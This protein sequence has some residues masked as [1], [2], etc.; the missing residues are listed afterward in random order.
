MKK[1]KPHEMSELSAIILVNLTAIAFFF[2]LMIII[3]SKILF[4]QSIDNAKRVDTEAAQHVTDSLKNNFD[5]MTQL[6][7]FPQ[8]L[9]AEVDFRSGT[10]DK[11]TD[12][13]LM[14]LMK[15]NPDIHCAWLVLEKGVHYKDRFY[16]KRYT[17][18]NGAVVEAAV[19]AIEENLKD[20]ATAPWYYRPLV[21]KETYLDA[22]SLHDDYGSNDR[23]P[24]YAATLSAPILVAGEVIGVYTVGLLYKDVL[25]L[26][27]DPLTGYDK[28]AMLMSQD[29][30]IIHSF[31]PELNGKNLAHLGYDDIDSIRDAMEHEREYDNEIMSPLIDKKIFLYLLPISFNS[32]S[33]RQVLYLLM[34]TPLDTLYKDAYFI[35]LIITSISF[36]CMVFIVGII[37]FAAN[38]VVQPIRDLAKKALHVASGDFNVDIFDVPDDARRGKSEVAVLRRA[39]N[40]MLRALH[41]NLRTVEKRVDER[42]S[43][44]TK[45]NNYINLLIESTSN[46]S[47]LLDKDLNILYYSKRFLTLLSIDDSSELLRKPLNVMLHD[48]SDADYA[49]RSKRRMSRIIS[50]EEMFSEDDAITWPNGEKR[51]YRIIYRRVKDDKDNF[52]GMVVVMHDLTD[53]RMEEAE[54]RINDM[55]YSTVVPC[56]V[57]DKEGCI[58]KYNKAAAGI[59]GLPEDLSPEDFDKRYFSMQPELQPNGISTETVKMELIREALEKGFSQVDGQLVKSDGTPLYVN[60]IVAR[61]AWLSGYLMV[62][63]HHD[64][65]DLKLKEAE[66]KETEERIKLM[67]DGNPMICMLGDEYNNILDCNQAALNIFGVSEKADFCRNF[68]KFYPELQPDGSDSFEKLHQI[69]RQFRSSASDIHQYE[70]MFRT[71]K[72]EPL[73]VETTLVRM[74]WKD[75]VR[76]LS[77]VRDLREIKAKEQEMLQSAERERKADLLREAAQ[78]ANEAK[79]QFLANMSHEI[80]TPMNAVLGMSELLLHEKLNKRQQRYAKDIKVSAEALL[81]IINDILDVSK[82]QSGKLSLMPV[83]FDFNMLIDNIGSMMHFLVHGKNII[84][85]L[86]MPEQ[87]PVCLYGDDIRLRQILINLLNNAIKF[88][89]EGYVE[90]AIDFT[91]TTI[92]IAVND[93]GAGIPEESIST[94]FEAFEQADTLMN[95]NTKGTGLGLTITKALVEMMGGHITVES[96]YGRGTSFYVEIPK[97]LGDETLI[98]RVDDKGIEVYAPEAKILVVDD[99]K[100]NLNVACGLLQ[101]CAINVETAESGRQA[102]EMVQQNHFDIVFMD[103]RMP[104]MSGVEATQ[105]IR[106]LGINVPIIALTASA[107]ADAKEMMLEAGMSDYLW[108]PIIKA[109]L[110]QILK[111]WIPADKLLTPQHV[112]NARE[113]SE[114]ERHKDFWEKIGQIE[115]LSISTG[116][117]RVDG[118]RGMYKKT[119]QLMVQEIEKSLKN[120]PDYLS[121]ND[122][123]NFRIEVHGIKGALANIGAMELS[124]KAFS[125]ETASDKAD[126]AFCVSNLPGFLEGLNDLNA[127]LKGAFALISQS[128]GIIEIPPELPHIFEKLTSAFYEMDLA[129]IDEEIEKLTALNPDGG[130]KEEIE[131]I[132]DAVLM[133]DYDTAVK[134]IHILLGDA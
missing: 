93:T 105:A 31:N 63:Y 84:F 32:G 2:I 34:G 104:E 74:K 44:L 120:L 24:E 6:L 27:N 25:E 28:V 66:A 30:T 42:T 90:L 38:R 22:V 11:A 75:T 10:A 92:K 112:M 126:M 108:K 39:F 111:K 8:Q 76:V 109:E 52:E 117:D 118:R 58:V 65:T 88:T 131:K 48:F 132:K 67:L 62:A 64:I 53:V 47:M 70:W 80:R 18:R 16:I 83:H 40:E 129:V 26:H 115:G 133:M 78:A 79:S 110:M 69:A 49:K 43:E 61:I 23:L 9:L 122:M 33:E 17:R 98:H 102:I 5:S 35:V 51:I 85:R 77:Y 73:P 94:L 100:T 97:V 81:D 54:R 4:T 45:L 20:P 59:F 99:N 86:I 71:A 68:Y 107:V 125:L 1:R 123:N 56:F 41:E 82:I 130:L 14:A 134:Q 127:K 91:D 57:W 19:S 116:L 21:T 128:G 103:Q 101:L 124:G 60:V 36:A 29:A 113:E 72:N 3:L 87:A 106:K 95:R 114:N 7:R 119:L 121:A 96:Q 13:V 37:Y 12:D 15:I 50:G 89:N 46:I 55:L